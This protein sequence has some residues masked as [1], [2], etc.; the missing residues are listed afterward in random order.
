MRLVLALLVAGCGRYAF[1]SEDAAVDAMDAG[2]GMPYVSGTA[3]SCS[4]PMTTTTSTTEID[5]SGPPC[6]FSGTDDRESWLVIATAN[7]VGS[8]QGA[9]AHLALHVDGIER[10]WGEP[11][12]PNGQGWQVFTLVAGPAAQHDARLRVNALNGID[13][14]ITDARIVAIPLGPASH[15]Q[16]A[17]RDGDAIVTDPI[18]IVQLA[19]V[20]EPG[21]YIVLGGAAAGERP[22]QSGVNW[23]VRYPDGSR[24]PDFG[25]FRDPLLPQMIVRRINTNG[26]PTTIG[27]NASGNLGSSGTLRDAQLVA[28]KVPP[29][30]HAMISTGF[31]L[32]TAPDSPAVTVQTE[33]SATPTTGRAWFTLQSMV[34]TVNGAPD[35]TARYLFSVDSSLDYVTSSFTISEEPQTPAFARLVETN[36]AITV[37]SA[38]SEP[39]SSAA[40]QVDVIEYTTLLFRVP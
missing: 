17:R 38:A 3:V 2:D 33:T 4:F 10:A 35:E 6:T 19:F 24:S 9:P 16:Y 29:D 26:G 37:S 30:S 18:D 34:G 1:Q 13:S 39:N 11:A 27:I 32:V 14:V 20:A 31:A 22:D 23:F 7:F 28:F 12:T 21:E 15:V 36:A 8:G 5:V 25:F 40:G